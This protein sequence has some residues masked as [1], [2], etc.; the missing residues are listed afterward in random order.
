MLKGAFT[1]IVT[2]FKNDKINYTKME[3]LIEFQISN[4]I[5]GIVVCGTTGES[6]TLTEREKNKLIKF[7]VDKVSGRVP[8]IAGTGC[9]NT[10]KTISHSKSAEQA[11]ADYVLL[12]SP[13]YNK[14][15]QN[16]LIKHYEAIADSIEIPSI[17]YNVPSRTG[18]DISAETTIKLSKHPK[19]IA[20]KEASGNIGKAIKIVVNTDNDF[21]VLSGNDDIIVPMLSIGSMGVISVISNILPKEIHDMCLYYENDE[22]DKAKE[23]QLFYSD[24]ID[25]LFIDVN[26]IPVKEAMNILGLDVGNVRLP[27]TKTS[28]LNAMQIKKSLKNIFSF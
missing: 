2:P 21:C 25:A 23:L 19:I 5:D 3:E 8:V 20:I 7:T 27:L 6:S 18:L 17:L 28:D 11:G 14:T 15:S 26:P 12:V 22:V 24:L 13:Y 9:N 10:A 1:A 4:E 16:G